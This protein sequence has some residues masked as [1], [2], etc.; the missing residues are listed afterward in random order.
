MVYAIIRDGTAKL[1]AIMAGPTGVPTVSHSPT[2]AKA[3][4]IAAPTG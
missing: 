2:S 4:Y 1:T 3:L